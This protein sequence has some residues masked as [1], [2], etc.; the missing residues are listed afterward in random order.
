MKDENDMHS[1]EN[2]P[3]N[4]DRRSFVKN[5]GIAGTGL[6]LGVSEFSGVSLAETVQPDPK[7]DSLKQS[8]SL[9]STYYYDERYID[10]GSSIERIDSAYYADRWHYVYRTEACCSVADYKTDT[11]EKNNAN[12]I[13][14]DEGFEIEELDAPNTVST[15]VYGNSDWGIG[16]QG[17]NLNGYTWGDATVDTLGAI[18]GYFSQVVGAVTTASKIVDYWKHAAEPSTDTSAKLAENWNLWSAS[19]PRTDE[20]SHYVEFEQTFPPSERFSKDYVDSLVTN[21]L[22]HELSDFDNYSYTWGIT[23]S[24]LSNPETASTSE[25]NKY[26]IEKVP[27]AESQVAMAGDN[28]LSPSDPVYVAKNPP[29]EIKGLGDEVTQ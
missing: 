22:N 7:I 10:A 9:P 27:A 14:G 23:I 24:V 26:G 20:L 29:V 4:A 17:P 12:V 11:G 3:L 1:N 15:S 6:T 25:L 5:L 16:V 18:I 19:N 13:T 8:A 28:S 21:N 2:R